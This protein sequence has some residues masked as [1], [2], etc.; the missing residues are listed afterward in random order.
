MTAQD[1]HSRLRMLFKLGLSLP[2]RDPVQ[3]RQALAALNESQIQPPLSEEWV[4]LV[5][6]L[7]PG[8]APAGVSSV[9]REWGVGTTLDTLTVAIHTQ[10]V[11][12]Q[13]VIEQHERLVEYLGIPD[14][15]AAD[16]DAE[17]SADESYDD[18]FRPEEG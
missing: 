3:L 14:P 10:S 5:Q 6:D 18:P 1:P 12:L 17:H 16:T 9:V 15:D 7:L 11:L 4:S 8:D 2:L 13:R